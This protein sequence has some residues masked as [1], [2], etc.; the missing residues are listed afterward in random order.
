MSAR[1]LPRLQNSDSLTFCI[2]EQL[3]TLVQYGILLHK[4]EEQTNY[5]R[6]VI[7]LVREKNEFDFDC[8]VIQ[9]CDICRVIAYGMFVG[10]R[11][12]SQ[13]IA[14]TLGVQQLSLL[15]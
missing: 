15:H 9:F 8:C 4:C 2:T 13:K 14:T 7:C 6:I 5:K 10:G 11:L 3:H 12:L 1:V